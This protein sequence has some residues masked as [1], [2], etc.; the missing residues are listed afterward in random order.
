MIHQSTQTR[1]IRIREVVSLTGLSRSYIYKLTK[2]GK[3]PER[4][5]L[6]EGGTAVAWL[7]SEIQ[8]WI[9]S[10]VSERNVNH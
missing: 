1:L 9:K 3:F 4:V 6:V 8:D 5:T 10:R 2:Q 7:E